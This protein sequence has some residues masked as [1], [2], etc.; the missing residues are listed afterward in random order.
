MR[1]EHQVEGAQVEV[2]PGVVGGGAPEEG[3][4]VGGVG[5]ARDGD[6]PEWKLIVRGLTSEP[7]VA[8]YLPELVHHP[9]H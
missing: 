3:V 6:R 4:E 8:A 7:R 5:H 9:G 2:A 1:Q